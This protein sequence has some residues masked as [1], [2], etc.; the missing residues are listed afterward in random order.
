VASLLPRRREG[1]LPQR[2][3]GTKKKKKKKKTLVIQVEIF[4]P[5][6]GGAGGW[7]RLEICTEKCVF[8]VDLMG[9]C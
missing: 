4:A 7:A 9:N 8:A 5:L 6:H 2:H 3:E 1:F